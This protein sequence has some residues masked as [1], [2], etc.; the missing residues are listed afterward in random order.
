MAARRKKKKRILTI[1]ILIMTAVVILLGWKMV[2]GSAEPG[3]HKDLM[4]S[5]YYIEEDGKKAEGYTLINGDAYYFDDGGKPAAEGWIEDE[6]YCEGKG[7]LIT[8]WRVLDGKVCYFY[9]K[10][11]KGKELARRARD[12]TT[13]GKIHIPEKGYIDG[14]QGQALALGIDVLNKRGWTL[15]NAYGYSSSLRFV[16]NGEETYGMKVENC[17]IQ[18]FTYGEGNCLAWAGTFCVMAKLLGKD[19]RLIWGTINSNNEDLVHGWTEIWEK[20]GIHV[21]DPRKHEGEDLAGFDFHYGD[22]GTYRYDENNKNYL[23]W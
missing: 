13:P 20:D 12:Y 19:C 22:K 5:Y 7:K 10:E 11:D 14:K 3:W 1:A 15:K 21:Y 2:S 6:Y 23:E 4:G 16:R 8:G 9:Q 17:A 18:G